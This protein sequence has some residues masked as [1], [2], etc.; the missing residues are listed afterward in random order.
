MKDAFPLGQYD[1]KKVYICRAYYEGR[2]IVGKYNSKKDRCHIPWYV[3]NKEVVMK[4]SFQVL[5]VTNHIV[6]DYRELDR[7]VENFPHFVPIGRTRC[8]VTTY[9]AVAEFK[10]KNGNKVKSVGEVY[11]NDFTKALFT[12]NGKIKEISEFKVLGCNPEVISL[13]QDKIEY[14]EKLGFNKTILS[15]NITYTHL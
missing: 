10:D 5:M 12:N 14:V 4:E 1:S 2:F 7:T 11:G 8:G 15:R 3:F 9:A 13:I 6:G